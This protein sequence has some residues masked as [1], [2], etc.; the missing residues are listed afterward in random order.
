[1]EPN[2]EL[3]LVLRVRS[4][5]K[6]LDYGDIPSKIDTGSVIGIGSIIIIFRSI[7]EQNNFG[8][9]FSLGLLASGWFVACI[10]QLVN[11]FNT[12]FN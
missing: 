8:I 5:W 9:I 7:K 6:Y 4:Y 10:L 11:S 12:E 1:L 3:C 2:F